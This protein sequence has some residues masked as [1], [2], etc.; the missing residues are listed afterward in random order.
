MADD[1]TAG[2]REALDRRQPDAQTRERAGTRR[3]GE[4]IDGGTP[5]QGFF[6]AGGKFRNISRRQKVNHLQI[7]SSR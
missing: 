6:G 4:E 7:L 1:L 5:W 3:R 2:E